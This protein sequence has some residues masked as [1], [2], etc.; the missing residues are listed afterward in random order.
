M[1]APVEEEP[2]LADDGYPSEAELERV[3]EWPI[4]TPLDMA[5]LLAYVGARW[6]D[7]ARGGWRVA[8]DP[9]VYRLATG[10]WSGN[11]ELIG[12]LQENRLFWVTCWWSS[13]RG[14]AYEFRIP[15]LAD[16]P[17]R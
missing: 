1:D 10:G 17:P 16:A 4:I 8:G 11:E 15:V 6:R 12:A 5:G 7:A 14:G 3:R 2:F 9:P 13:H